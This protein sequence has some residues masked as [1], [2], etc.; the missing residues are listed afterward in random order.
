MRVCGYSGEGP[1]LEWAIASGAFGAIQ[2]SVNLAD[3]WTA[4]TLLPRAVEAG[5]GVIAKRPL[6]NAA[7]R[8]EDRPVGR[9]E[10]PYW[11]R[12][13]EMDIEPADGDWIR[14]AIRFSAFAPGV[15]TAIVGTSSAGNLRD[16]V[17]AVARGPLPADEVERWAAAFA[18]HLGQ[19][20]PQV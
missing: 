8:F 7:W 20:P 6:A 9:Y 3:Q 18:P 1:E 15:S 13:R 11:E 4:T 19:W 14:T 16:V 2:T 10:E 17:D 5:L 12:L